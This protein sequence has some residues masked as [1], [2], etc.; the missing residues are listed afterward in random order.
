MNIKEIVAEGVNKFNN[1]YKE[2]SKKCKRISFDLEQNKIDINN[3]N[4]L[5]DKTFFAFLADLLKAFK[6][7][8]HSELMDELKE[9]ENLTREK[10]NAV[11]KIELENNDSLS[12]EQKESVNKVLNADNDFC[13]EIVGNKFKEINDFLGKAKELGMDKISIQ[14]KLDDFA[15]SAKDVQKI[16]TQNLQNS[17]QNIVKDVAKNAVKAVLKI[18]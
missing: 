17:M 2:F 1:K 18:K 5:A 3:D 10:L 11:L 16:T 12:K 6:K 14:S 9:N 13:V 8:K 4:S 7:D 15:F